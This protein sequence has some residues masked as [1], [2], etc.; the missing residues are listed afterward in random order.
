MARLQEKE[1]YRLRM[2][3]STQVQ[4]KMGGIH[5]NDVLSPTKGSSVQIP[6]GSVCIVTSVNG[7]ARVMDETNSRQHS[8]ELGLFPNGT[9][10]KKRRYEWNG[11]RMEPLN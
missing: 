11:E 9:T 7:R 2:P 6:T 3:V 8:L 1:L 4:L 10:A 5:M